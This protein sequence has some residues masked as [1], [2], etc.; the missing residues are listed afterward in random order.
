M[1]PSIG[2]FMTRSPHTIGQEQSLEHAHEVMRTHH[3]RHL[4]VLAGGKLVGLLSERDL[5]S[6]GMPNGEDESVVTVS[7]AMSQGVF[8]APASA[9]MF[10]VAREMALHKFGCAVI[11][12]GGHVVG[13]FTTTDALRA[14][15]EMCEVP[16]KAS[17]A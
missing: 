2:R 4:P 12:E 5:N 8:S 15:A 3:I 9:S 13:M 7:E 6:V 11:V 14:L 1:P 17:P 10:E 16:P